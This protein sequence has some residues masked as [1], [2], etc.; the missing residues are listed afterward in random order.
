MKIAI[1]GTF[2]GPCN[3]IGV[4]K[5]NDVHPQQVFGFPT[6]SLVNW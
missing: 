1:H 4:T 3:E 6:L 2:T 5:L